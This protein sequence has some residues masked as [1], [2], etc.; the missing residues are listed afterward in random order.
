MQILIKLKIE[1]F[2]KLEEQ[3]LPQYRISDSEMFKNGIMNY[4]LPIRVTKDHV[5]FVEDANC[6]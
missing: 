2:A 5:I 3:L 4:I 1:E 6:E